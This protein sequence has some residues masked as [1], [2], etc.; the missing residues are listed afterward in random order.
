M[1]PPHTLG[2]VVDP[3]NPVFAEFPTEDFSD[4]QWWEIVNKA[5]PMHLEDF[6]R[7]F[8]PLVQ[9]IDTWFLNRR[10]GLIFEARVG[11][12]RLIVSGADLSPGIGPDRPA[13][14]QLYYSITKYMLSPDFHPAYTVEYKTVK[15]LFETGSRFVFSTHTKSSPDELKPKSPT[16]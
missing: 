14:R 8:R 7:G 4:L 9:P 12:G 6:P 2:I 13:A 3:R 10:L 15:D 5:Q 11:K 16:Q 1:R